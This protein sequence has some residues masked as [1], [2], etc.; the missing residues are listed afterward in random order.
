MH[1]SGALQGRERCHQLL[2]ADQNINYSYSCSRNGN[3]KA[4]VCL[5]KFAI[6][7]SVNVCLAVTVQ[8]ALNH[9]FISLLTI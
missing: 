2:S 7:R 6:N 5:L 4:K 3:L 9:I 8:K 1:Q